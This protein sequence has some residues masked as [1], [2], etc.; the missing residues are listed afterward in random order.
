[1]NKMDPVRLNKIRKAAR[2]TDPG[3][4]RYLLMPKLPLFNQLEIKREHGKI[5][6]AGAPRRMVGRDFLFA[7][8]LSLLRRERRGNEQGV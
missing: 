3:D 6:A 1:M 7:Q 8:R 4:G 2:T 5:A